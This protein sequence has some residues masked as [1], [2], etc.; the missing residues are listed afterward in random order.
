MEISP[1]KVA[2]PGQ[3]ITD[4]NNRLLNT[5]WPDEIDGAGWTYGTN[6]SYL[7]NLC[8]YWTNDYSWRKTENDI[9]SYDNFIAGVDGY[10]IH[11]IHV[12]GK[13]SKS[14]PLIITH[15]W[16]GSF[17]EMMK[18]IPYLT[19]GTGFTF[20]LVIPSVIGFGFSSKPTSPGCNSA[21]IADLWHKL[22]LGL[23]Y[24]KYGAQ[25]GDIGAG[26]S[27]WL[28]LKHP[29]NVIGLHL[30][31]IPGS[32]QPYMKPGDNLTAEETIYKQQ[33]AEWYAEEG[34]YGSIQ[35]TKPQTLA[36]GLNDSPAGLCGWI[37][38]KFQSWTDSDGN[39]ESVI[40][41]DELL[42]NVSLYWFT[43]SLPS[44]IRLYKESRKAPLKFGRDDRIN[45][46]VAFTRFPNELPTP[47]RSFV[48][49]SFNI[50]QWTEMP[51]GGHF[52][53]MEQPQLLA[54]N[55]KGFFEQI[56]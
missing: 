5:R 10:Q 23:G 11:F 26:I 6:L 35:S 54:A 28:S 2:I 38:E 33:I 37:I 24:T 4:L 9:N 34:A 17:L 14:V 43:Q 41:Y 47:P 51:M 27:S 32:Y 16:P 29:D 50:I 31:F 40:S 12:K 52:A 46:P 39:P 30:N 7:K 8:T 19:E 25:G 44:S 1:F 42:A 15:G 13:G 36:Y 45:T 48:E 18:M 55:I 3:Q 20:D 21:V 49:K 53:A 22:M 56:I